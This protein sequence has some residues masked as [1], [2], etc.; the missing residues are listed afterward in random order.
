[1]IY[2]QVTGWCSMVVTAE[3][4]S[5]WWIGQANAKQWWWRSECWWV[6][7]AEVGA[8]APPT[9]IYLPLPPL[10]GPTTNAYLPLRHLHHYW[11]S[12]TL[13]H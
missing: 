4:F 5:G 13:V 2:D 6:T 12:T 11:S 10:P 9:D 7:K 3:R 1:M 8:A